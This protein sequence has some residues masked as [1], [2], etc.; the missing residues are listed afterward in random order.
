MKMKKFSEWEVQVE[1]HILSIKKE[2]TEPDY[3]EKSYCLLFL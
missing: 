2:T 1:N 3:N